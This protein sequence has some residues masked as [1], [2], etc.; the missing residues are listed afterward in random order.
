MHPCAEVDADTM[1]VQILS[2][3]FLPEAFKIWE[4]ESKFK[5][6]DSTRQICHYLID[7][8]ANI[9]GIV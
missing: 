9:M 1:D 2:F 4:F 3:E 8:A 5:G 6:R 7:E